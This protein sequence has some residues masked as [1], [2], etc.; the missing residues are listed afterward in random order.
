MTDT[1]PEAPQFTQAEVTQAQSAEDD[2]LTSVMNQAQV[3][4]L[5]QRTVMLRLQLDRALDELRVVKAHLEERDGP[6]APED[7]DP[8]Y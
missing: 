6:A 1:A 5:H 7:S 3:K 2:L 8:T 4:F